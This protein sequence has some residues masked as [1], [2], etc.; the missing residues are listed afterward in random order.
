MQLLPKVC[1]TLPLRKGLKRSI[2]F[3]RT[4][5]VFGHVKTLLTAQVGSA[6]QKL[7]L[8]NFSLT[9]AVCWLCQNVSNTT[10]SESGFAIIFLV[11]IKKELCCSHNL[12]F[13]FIHPCTIEK[14]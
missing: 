12:K 10:L 3:N 11:D 1:F 9:I 7:N 2:Y 8:T 14:S 13:I 5:N 4:V 6:N